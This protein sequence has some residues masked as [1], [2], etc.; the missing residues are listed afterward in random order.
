[1]IKRRRSK[2]G[3]F[4]K[5]MNQEDLLVEISERLML[6]MNSS[7]INEA[8][9]ANNLNKDA[10]Y[11]DGLINGFANITVREL[12]DVFSLF[13][14]VVSLK[15]IDSGS[16]ESKIVQEVRKTIFC[17]EQPFFENARLVLESTTH[18]YDVK[19]DFLKIEGIENDSNF[20]SI[21]DVHSWGGNIINEPSFVLKCE[22]E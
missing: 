11:V 4:Q 16:A 9:L 19:V 6:E 7:G 12:A 13:N 2:I 8:S 10:S 17:E 5:I 15:L 18:R 21:D 20:L 3:D 1:M 22:V 14:K